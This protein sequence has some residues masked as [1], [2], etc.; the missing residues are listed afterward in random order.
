MLGFKIDLQTGP[1]G[2]NKLFYFFVIFLIFF[3]ISIVILNKTTQTTTPSLPYNLTKPVNQP[4]PAEVLGKKAISVEKPLNLKIDSLGINANVESVGL[5]NKN[6]MDVPQNPDNVAWY[7]LGFKPGEKGSAVIAGHLDRIT[8]APA[9]FWDLGKLNTGD[10]IKVEDEN[11][12]LYTFKV[13]DK[14]IYDFD[15]VPLE[16]VFASK[17]KP[18]LNLI[19]CNGAFDKNSSNYSK[20]LV[21]YSELV[22]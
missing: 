6:R 20:R 8:G 2:M 3:G 10:I 1:K 5:D 9:V 15:K 17:D 16:V 19:T 14:K 4:T 7:N 22:N 13:T 21:V 12:N 11:Q 18:R